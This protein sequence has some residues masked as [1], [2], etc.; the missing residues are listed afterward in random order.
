MIKLIK[1]F[2]EELIPNLTETWRTKTYL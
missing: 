1:I 2:E